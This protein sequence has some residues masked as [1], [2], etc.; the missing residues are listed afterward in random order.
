MQVAGCGLCHTDVG[1]YSGEVKPNQFP[2]ILGHEIS[3]R[4]V[5]AGA[6]C[7]EL[8]GKSVIIPAVMPCGDCELCDAGRGNI[9]RSQ[10]MPGNDFDGGFA[11]HI[12]VP[13]RFLCTVPD[14]LGRYELQQLAV[15]ADAVT[16]PYQAMVRS[17]LGEGDLAIVVGIGGLGTYMTQLARNAGAKVIAI[18]IDAKKLATAEELGAA[19]TLNAAELSEKDIKKA[20]R[21]WVKDNKA[22]ATRWKVFEMSGTGAGQT[23]AFSLLSFAGS[24]AVVGFTMDKINV[25]LS[26]IMAFDAEVFGNWA[27]KPEHY[28]AVVEEV[29]RDR[30]DLMN[31]IEEHPLDS[32]NDI[33]PLSLQHKIER[34]VIFVP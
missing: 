2:V 8:E 10:K 13:A 23:T 34:R 32:V 14:E 12:R 1:F 30:I 4:V 7:R 3:G 24:L 20:V 11:S 5:A 17:G 31:F 9:C 6:G 15:I 25:R 28:P 26:N 33:I 22:P 29:L 21:G 18:D 27:C 16:T 19:L